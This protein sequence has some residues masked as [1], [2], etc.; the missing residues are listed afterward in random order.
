MPIDYA[1]DDALREMSRD[2]GGTS[3]RRRG[4]RP[5]AGL[6]P[7]N[8]RP[9]ND[10]EVRLSDYPCPECDARRVVL[11]LCDGGTFGCWDR[12][13]SGCRHIDYHCRACHRTHTMRFP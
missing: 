7:F 12:Q 1:A 3:W 2:T 4:Y 11:K 5:L 8:Y 13:R 10:G 9:V 6:A